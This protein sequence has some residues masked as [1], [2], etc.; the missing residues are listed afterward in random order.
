MEDIETPRSKRLDYLGKIMGSQTPLNQRIENKRM[1]IGRQKHAYMTWILSLIMLGVLIYELVYNAKQQGNPFSFK[2][3]TLKLSA[4]LRTNEGIYFEALRESN[5]WP[6]HVWISPS[7]YDCYKSSIISIELINLVY[8]LSLPSLY[9]TS[10]IPSTKYNACWLCVLRLHPNP[11][12]L[13]DLPLSS[14]HG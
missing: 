10:P 14:C 12:I 11:H 6:L 4:R 9:A 1:G 13:P 8:R 3:T 5:A 2:V 7:G